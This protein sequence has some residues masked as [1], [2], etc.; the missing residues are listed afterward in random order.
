MA[1][2]RHTLALP[3]VSLSYLEWP[4]GAD[5]P[6]LLLHGLADQG[7]AWSPVAEA[8]APRAHL[9]APDMRGHGDSAKPPTGYD[10][11]TV[12][13]D[14]QGLMA[15]LGWESAHV[16]GHSWMGKVAAIWAT[17]HPAQVRSLTLVDPIFIYGL[18]ALFRL[19]FPLFYRVLPF[20]QAMGPF[21]TWEEA[22][23]KA[24]SLKQYRAWMPHQQALFTA[25]LVQS[26]DGQWRSKFTPAARDGIFD[27]VLRRPGLVRSLSVPAL[28]LQPEAGVN[29]F[30][31]QLAP[32]RRY[33]EQLAVVTVPGNHWAFV[34]EPEPFTEALGAFLAAQAG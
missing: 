4:A 28:F 5:T 15:H 20:L 13:A 14:L 2:S 10:A 18:P 9:V 6:V 19:T 34:V 3:D 21:A 11:T 33:L 23:A 8:L 22:E 7:L 25:S 30:D 16:V 27:D 29:R 26:D 12:I 24:R 1:P 32:Y 17:E 31:W